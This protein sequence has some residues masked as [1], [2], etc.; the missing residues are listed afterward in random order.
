MEPDRRQF[1]FDPSAGVPLETW[2]ANLR[3]RGWRPVHG[4]GTI[5]RT[6]TGMRLCVVMRTEQVA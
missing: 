4:A 5:V 1:E 3:V 6:P 2:M